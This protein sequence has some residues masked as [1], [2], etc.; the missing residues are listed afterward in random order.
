MMSTKKEPKEDEDTDDD[1]EA[2]VP[3]PPEFGSINLISYTKEQSHATR[4]PVGCAVWADVKSDG[5]NLSWNEGVVDLVLID[6]MTRETVYRVKFTRGDEESDVDATAQFQNLWEWQLSFAIGS[7][8]EIQSSSD[9]SKWSGGTIVFQ[10]PG[11]PDQRTY[12]V[13]VGASSR[14]ELKVAESRIRYPK[15]S[16]SPIA[17]ANMSRGQSGMQT[18][19]RGPA[20]E[21]VTAKDGSEI[22]SLAE[23]CQSVTDQGRAR[24]AKNAP[25]NEIC[26]SKN[27]TTTRGIEGSCTSTDRHSETEGG[28]N[29]PEIPPSVEVEES[30]ARSEEA[31]RR[32]DGVN[33]QQ[34]D[35]SDADKVFEDNPKLMKSVGGMEPI[36]RFVDGALS[37]PTQKSPDTERKD[38]EDSDVEISPE[39]P[40]HESVDMEPRTSSDGNMPLSRA[41]NTKRKCTPAEGSSNSTE[42]PTKITKAVDHIEPKT[43]F[44][45]ND[46]TSEDRME[47]ETASNGNVPS[48]RWQA[49]N[50]KRKSAGSPNSSERPTKTTVVAVNEPCVLTVNPWACRRPSGS[51]L[52]RFLIGVGGSKIKRFQ[53]SSNCSISLMPSYWRIGDTLRVRIKTCPGK[54]DLVR[55]R[56]EILASMMDF[57][58]DGTA[59]G[60]ARERLRH[61]VLCSEEGP[62]SCKQSN[63]CILV[64]KNGNLLWSRLVEVTQDLKGELPFI[65]IGSECFIK[66]YRRE[67]K[68]CKPYILV[69]GPDPSKVNQAAGKV[70]ETISGLVDSASQG[71]LLNARPTTSARTSP[72]KSFE[73]EFSKQTAITPS[74]LLEMKIPHWLFEARTRVYDHI[75]GTAPDSLIA[76][77]NQAGCAISKAESGSLTIQ[78]G[79]A[80]SEAESGFL[81]I[82]SGENSPNFGQMF[83]LVEDSL[84][85]IL[86][87]ENDDAATD[88]LLY[89]LSEQTRRFSPYRRHDAYNI[90]QTRNIESTRYPWW[91]WAM[92]LP[93]KR[94]LDETVEYHGRFLAKLRPPGVHIRVYDGRHAPKLCEPYVLVKG[95]NLKQVEWAVKVMREDMIRHQQKCGC[96]PKWE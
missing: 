70:Q 39:S 36:A 27:G 21:V 33:E 84:L 67:I 52:F 85:Q 5:A 19:T 40:M 73:P 6:I 80:I 87:I 62:L 45:G 61:E 38:Q 42:R 11:P 37:A 26:D 60:N 51:I 94:H 18:E 47:P 13:R 12:A 95:P 58:D 90:I 8:V 46:Q 74:D 15:I 53:N 82:H 86:K 30:S 10:N 48:D 17:K 4:F 3:P 7:K 83:H 81:T 78:A 56:G 59:E 65:Q 66:V 54:S 76:F 75:F 72:D 69:Y 43:S 55:A 88:R 63:G 32:Q 16:D 23:A 64:S 9:T 14:I 22:S 1:E 96:M 35:D 31:H 20:S 92:T 2:N 24:K 44:D 57:I 91:T 49:P 34:Q 79:C 25:A 41:P 50:T 89:D 28:N 68:V 77:L 71:T 29:E 93:A